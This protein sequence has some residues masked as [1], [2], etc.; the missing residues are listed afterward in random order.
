MHLRRPTSLI[1]IPSF[2]RK[3]S[4]PARWGVFGRANGI[5]DYSCR[6]PALSLAPPDVSRCPRRSRPAPYVPPAEQIRYSRRRPPDSSDSPDAA[7]FAPSQSTHPPS[8]PTALSARRVYLAL[9]GA[10]LHRSGDQDCHVARLPP[11]CASKAAFPIW[12]QALALR[13]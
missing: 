2:H 7:T 12:K 1:I 5:S 4:Y 10:V 6:Q 11:R 13:C 8:R 3:I 9:C